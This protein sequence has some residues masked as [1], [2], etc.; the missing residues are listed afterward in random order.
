MPKRR[1]KEIEVVA[2]PRDFVMAR[3][4]AA[5][6]SAQSGIDA[7]LEAALHFAD[8]DDDRQGKKRKELLDDADESLGIASRAVQ[9]AQAGIDDCSK[10]DLVTGEPDVDEVDDDDEDDGDDDE[11]VEDDQ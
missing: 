1:V 8:P 3:I 6:A 2:D 4:A 7:L 9:A 10:E 11:I 5:I